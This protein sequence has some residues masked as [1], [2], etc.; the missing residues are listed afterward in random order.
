MCVCVWLAMLCMEMFVNFCM[1]CLLVYIP[2]I[3]ASMGG[4]G[5]NAFQVVKRY[6]FPIIISMSFAPAC[7]NS[8]D[9]SNWGCVRTRDMQANQGNNHI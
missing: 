3:C 4:C 5:L 8:T 2:L 7:L 1:F 6:K 9:K